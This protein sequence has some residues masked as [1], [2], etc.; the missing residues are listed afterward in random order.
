[1]LHHKNLMTMGREILFHPLFMKTLIVINLLGSVYGYY[2]YREQ[3]ANT[4]FI[5]WIFTPDSPLS[6]TLLALTLLLFIYGKRVPYLSYLA[7]TTTIKYGLWAVFVNSHYWYISGQWHWEEVMLWASHLGMA[8]EGFL[9][10][11]Y[12]LPGCKVWG[13]ISLWLIF[14]DY[15]DYV[16]KLH[17]YLYLEEQLPTVEVFTYGL[18]AF[19]ILGTLWLI[20]PGRSRLKNGT[21]G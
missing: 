18:T 4:P 11:L 10:L 2:W 20:S 21:A 1:M 13:V 5:Y 15:V 16:W 17:P 9:Y 7:C 8:I 19:I 3:L 12:L 6:T 14:N